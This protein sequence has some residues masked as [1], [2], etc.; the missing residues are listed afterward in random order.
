MNSSKPILILGKGITGESFRDY[1]S[2]KKQPFITYDTRIGKDDF[3]LKKNLN[4]NFISEEEIDFNNLKFIACSPGFDLNHNIIKTAK[5]KNIEIKSDIN[6]F[7]EEKNNP[8]TN[9]N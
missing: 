6:I 3:N 4:F 9:K 2:K 7:L 5:E 1:F 8:S